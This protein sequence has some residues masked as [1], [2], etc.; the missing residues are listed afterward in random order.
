MSDSPVPQNVSAPDESRAGF[1]YALSAFFLWGLLPFFM[2][3]IAHIDTYQVLAH[4]VI[5]SIPIA[6]IILL[7]TGR[8]Q[9]LLQIFKSRRKFAIMMLSSAVISVNWGVYIWSI[10]SERSIEAALGYYINPLISV[11]LGALFLGEKMDRIQIVAIALAML[12]VAIL[13]LAAGVFPWV[14]ITLACSFATYGFIRKT[15]DIGPTQGFMV[16]VLILSV[17]AVPYAIWL[18]WSGV[19]HF[20]LNTTDTLLLLGCGPVTAIPLILFSYGARRLRLSTIGLMQYIV[21]TMI[22]LIGVF[23]F[24]EPFSQWQLVA[25]LLI[26][27][28]IVLYTWSSMRRLRA[29]HQQAKS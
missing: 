8:F 25:F 6:L 13:T 9:G 5:W 23:I 29:E 19:S 7:L 27:T 2:K 11:A 18:Q 1:A 4:R 16:E 24:N 15:V 26:W 28:A 10:A 3:A 17:I 21:P 14:A 20:G 22:F 12:A